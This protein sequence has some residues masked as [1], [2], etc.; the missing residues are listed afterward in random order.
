MVTYRPDPSWRYACL[1]C[2]GVIWPERTLLFRSGVWKYRNHRDYMNYRIINREVRSMFTRTNVLIRRF[3]NCSVSVKLSLFRSYCSNLYDTGL[4]H[5]YLKGS[6]QKLRS[7]YN[8]CVKMFFGYNRRYS[9]TQTLSEL[10]L[11]SFDTLLLNSSA[12]FLRRWRNCNN[13]VV[14][15]LSAVLNWL[16]LVCVLC[17]LNW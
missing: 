7:C 16:V 4:W 1:F 10:N 12:R 13:D 17:F 11:S 15:H 14:T 5:T 6:M 2:M 8:K 3:G 9:M